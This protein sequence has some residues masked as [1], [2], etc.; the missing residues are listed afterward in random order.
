[1]FGKPGKIAADI[2]LFASQFGFVTA[3]VY[4]IAQQIGGPLS[5]IECAT[6]TS[7]TTIIPCSTGHQIPKWW[8]LLIC[9]AIWVPL[10]FIRK[11]E[12]FAKF[13]VFGDVLIIITILV[14]ASYA[15]YYVG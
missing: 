8:F 1:M 6:A 9:C 4:F 13:H 3:Y 11:I 15:G 7:D 5:I 10:V 2:V 12:V 14:I